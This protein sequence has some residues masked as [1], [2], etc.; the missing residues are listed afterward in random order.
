MI[1]DEPTNHLDI[2]YQL[3]I[4]SIVHSLNIGVL[5]AMHDLSLAATFCTYIYLLKNGKVVTSG[6]PEEVLTQ[7]NI[8]YAY[9][10]DCRVYPNPIDGR[11][12]ITYLR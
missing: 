3:Q 8:K 6:I 10:V 4:M 7:E 9:E 5:A 1:L 2:K 12:T 11:L